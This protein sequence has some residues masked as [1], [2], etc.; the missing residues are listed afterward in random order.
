MCSFLLVSGGMGLGA[1][2]WQ[3]VRILRLCS[4]VM[5]PQ[6]GG[7]LKQVEVTSLSLSFVPQRMRTGDQ[8]LSE[9]SGV[10]KRFILGSGM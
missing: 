10:L 7:D 9:P 3:E 1:E 6:V 2:S 5:R 4:L 8:R